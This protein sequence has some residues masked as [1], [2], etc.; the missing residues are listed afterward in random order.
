LPRSDVALLYALLVTATAIGRFPGLNPASLWWDDLWVAT[1]A[2]LRE[3][4][5]IPNPNPPGFLLILWILSRAISNPEWSLQLLPFVCGLAV[6]PLTGAVVSWITE[7]PFLGLAAAATAA[8][9][10]LL[11]TYSVFVKPFTLGAAATAALLLVAVAALDRAGV[12]ALWTVDAVGLLTFFFSLSAIPASFLLVHLLCLFALADARRDL[13]A[14][15]ARLLPVVLFDLV[16]LAWFELDVRYRSNPLLIDF[17]VGHFM[18]SASP[19]GVL[20]FFAKQ[21]WAVLQ[22]A[23]PEPVRGC[24]LLAVP[25]LAA[26]A[27]RRARLG[28][29]FALYLLEILILSRLHYVPLGARTEAFAIPVFLVLML[30]AFDLAPRTLRGRRALHGTLAVATMVLA[31]R[32]PFPSR[33]YDVDDAFTV[34]E[35]ARAAGQDNAVLVY[36]WASWLV[37]YYSDWP[38]ELHRSDDWV[39]NF[40]P[41]FTRANTQILEVRPRRLD[42]QLADFLGG[43]E[44]STVFYIATRE[45]HRL[46]ESRIFAELDRRGYEGKLLVRSRKSV[47]Y[48]FDRQPV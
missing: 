18:R 8:L 38:Y 19:V 3:A 14:L 47:L 9:N 17:W 25:G 7:S 20:H 6:I 48:V 22:E 5:T 35:L 10:P 29:F 30:A 41:Q 39:C 16:L 27:V 26:I 4:L 46:R 45:N 40:L 37:A 42:Q 43:R 13:R 24:A 21:G 34:E 28:L 11:A 31:V 12:R 44:F 33:Y 36:P 1:L 2:S 15:G 23:L 32:D